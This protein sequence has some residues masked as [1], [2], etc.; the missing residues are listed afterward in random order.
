MSSVA[1]A[2]ST[3]VNPLQ[4]RVACANSTSVN[5]LQNRELHMW[6]FLCNVCIKF[7]NGQ[8]WKEIMFK[9]NGKLSSVIMFLT[10]F[11]F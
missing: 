11:S 4:N 5:P 3:S 9:L 2:N 6:T 10:K 8:I 7:L 1:C